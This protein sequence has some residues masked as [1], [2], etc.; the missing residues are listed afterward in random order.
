MEEK[1]LFRWEK[2]ASV[3]CNKLVN[4]CEEPWAGSSWY[5]ASSSPQP[6]SWFRSSVSLVM[7]G[8]PTKPPCTNILVEDV[9]FSCLPVIYFSGSKSFLL[10][11]FIWCLAPLPLKHTTAPDLL[12]KSPYNGTNRITREAL[13]NARAVH[14][15]CVCRT[16]KPAVSE[17]S[18]KQ[19]MA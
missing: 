16:K 8:T 13:K 3:L 2:H 17:A 4:T 12:C 6:C 15:I 1:Q 19:G 5:I 10:P 7:D 14:Y 9:F 18:L 11:S